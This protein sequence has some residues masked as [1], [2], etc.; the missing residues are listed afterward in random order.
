MKTKDIYA[1]FG[2]APSTLSD[3]GKEENKKN[4]LAQLLKNISSEEAKE[5]IA[6]KNDSQMK[7]MMLLSTVNCSIGN[8]ANHFTLTGLKKLFYKDEPFDIYDKYALKTIKN[9]ALEE[10]INDFMTYY[11]ISPKR[12]E[13]LLA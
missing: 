9:E 6:K 7:P 13:K 4:T 12:V 8:K 3:W 5:I 1:I 11:K 2:I 10:E